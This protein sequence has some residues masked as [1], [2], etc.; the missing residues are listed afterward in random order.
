MQECRIIEPPKPIHNNNTCRICGLSKPRKEFRKIWSLRSTKIKEMK[1]WCKSCQK[2]W[3]QA[4][5]FP[6][7]QMSF[8][9]HLD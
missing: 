4:R 5:D 7:P 2:A 9:V 1:V 8:E 6:T 3:K